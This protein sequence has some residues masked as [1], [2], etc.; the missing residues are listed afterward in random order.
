LQTEDG[1][2]FTTLTREPQEVDWL[3][4]A[5]LIQIIKAKSDEILSKLNLELQRQRSIRLERFSKQKKTFLFSKRYRLLVALLIF[6]G[7]GV[8]THDRRIGSR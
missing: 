7:A 3:S 8:V 1:S 6:A 4:S 5:D 2:S